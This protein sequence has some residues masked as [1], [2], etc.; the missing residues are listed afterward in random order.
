MLLPQHNHLAHERLLHSLVFGWVG[1]YFQIVHTLAPLFLG[2]MFFDTI[3]VLST[4]HL[5]SNGFHLLFLKDYELDHDLKLSSDFFK[6]AFQHMSHLSA[7]DLSRM[8]FEHLQN[9]FHMKDSINGFS[10]SA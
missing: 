1:E 5:Q 6:L 9:H 3:L 8:N 7:S 4:L 2:P 10:Y